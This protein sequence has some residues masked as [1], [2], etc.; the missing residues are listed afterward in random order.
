MIED[1]ILIDGLSLNVVDTAGLRE[2]EGPV[3]AEGI[4]RSLDE[5]KK[6]EVKIIVTEHE[7]LGSDE[8]QWVIDNE[9]PPENLIV[10]HNKIDLYGQHPH[11]ETVKGIRHVY[12]SMKTGE[13]VG[14]LRELLG[15]ASLAGE[16]TEN[17]VLARERHIQSLMR[18]TTHITAGLTGFRMTGQGEILAEDLKNTQ[19]ALGEITGEFHT[20]D[21]LGEIFSRFCIGK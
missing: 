10:L 18:A 11:T 19:K 9:I 3:E 20:E 15:R 14:L 6:A 17:L 21:L 13:G 7:E 16:N 12:A 5:I 2:P 4:R 1:T 8:R